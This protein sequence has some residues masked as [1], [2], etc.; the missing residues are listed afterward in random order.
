M[1]NTKN[2]VVKLSYRLLFDDKK[3][4]FYI[5]YDNK[6]MYINADIIKDKSKIKKLL[7]KQMKHYVQKYSGSRANNM[8]QDIYMDLKKQIAILT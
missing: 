4:Q 1:N 5:I 6:K 8:K 7:K 3:K 2:K